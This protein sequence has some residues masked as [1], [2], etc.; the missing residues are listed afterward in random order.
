VSLLDWIEVILSLFT[1]VSG[2]WATGFEMGRNS[3]FKQMLEMQQQENEKMRAN[4][5]LGE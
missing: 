1:I 5:Q 2:L 3:A 4:Y